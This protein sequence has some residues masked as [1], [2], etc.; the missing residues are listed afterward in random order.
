[1]NNLLNT[2]QAAACREDLLALRIYSS[3]LIGQDLDLKQQLNPSWDT[4]CRGGG[5]CHGRS[6]FQP[7]H[8]RSGPRG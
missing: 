2:S 3:R 8:E 4:G 7:G 1:M 6:E 5:L